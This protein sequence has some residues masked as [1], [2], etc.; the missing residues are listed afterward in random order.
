MTSI[1][2]DYKSM[3][4]E[5]PHDVKFITIT[6]ENIWMF[7]DLKTKRELNLHAVDSIRK[8]LLAG[9][10]FYSPM[11]VNRIGPSEHPKA[12]H[13]IDGH[14][15]KEGMVQAFKQNK[16]LRLRVA[17]IIFDNLTEAQELVV[18]DRINRTTPPKLRDKLYVHREE[19][20]IVNHVVEDFPIVVDY[21]QVHGRKTKPTIKLTLLFGAHLSCGKPFATTFGERDMAR[22]QALLSTVYDTMSAFANDLKI[23]SEGR[24][25]DRTVFRNV[26]LMMFYRLWYLNCVEHPYVEDD[27]DRSR[28]MFSARMKDVIDTSKRVMDA[29]RDSVS[30]GYGSPVLP[31]AEETIVNAFNARQKYRIMTTYDGWK[32]KDEEL[33]EGVK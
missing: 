3:F 32:R 14:H 22:V 6:A 4:L 5:F 1:P 17:F 20:P 11:A 28:E 15:R 12:F 2:E 25:G 27:M 29:L 19:F 13:L 18:F 9:E 24:W 8:S 33:E 30:V 10:Y 7:V 16:Y 23:Y 31:R 21:G 26:N